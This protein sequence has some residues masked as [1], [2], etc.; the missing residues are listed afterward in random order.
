[1]GVETSWSALVKVLITLEWEPLDTGK[2][3]KVNKF[4]IWFINVIFTCVLATKI[5]RWNCKIFIHKIS[6]IVMFMWF[7]FKFKMFAV[8]LII[9]LSTVRA[10]LIRLF[11][12]LFVLFCRIK[13]YYTFTKL[14]SFNTRRLDRLKTHLPYNFQLF[15]LRQFWAGHFDNWIIYFY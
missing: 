12:V 3:W 11:W 5:G 10:E 1:M 6:R 4:N 2:S 7:F 15:P 13:H 14:S 9:W 8:F